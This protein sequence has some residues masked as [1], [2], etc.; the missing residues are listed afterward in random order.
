MP[1][2]SR[3]TDTKM[4]DESRLSDALQRAG[5]TVDVGG[6]VVTARN[7]GETVRFSRGRAGEAFVTMWADR[8][9]LQAVQR[10]YAELGVRD[11]ARR[12]GYSV[13]QSDG[14]KLTLINRRG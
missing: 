8:A 11:W 12:R 14:R 10:Q 1:C 13:A 2:S 3:V 5:W 9:G 7:A 6:N 4:L